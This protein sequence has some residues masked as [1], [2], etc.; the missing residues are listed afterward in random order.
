MMYALIIG[1]FCVTSI[2][3]WFVQILVRQGFA[4]YHQA[5]T[6]Q[7]RNDLGEMFLFLDPRQVWSASLVLCAACAVVTYLIA[8]NVLIV[9]MVSAVMLFA[10]PYV[11]SYAR[12]YRLERLERQLP[13][14]LLAL[15]GALRAGSGIQSALRQSVKHVP[16]PLSQELGLMLREQRM[17]VSFEQ[18]LSNLSHRVPT[19]SLSLIVSALNIA[20]QSGG[21]LAETLERIAVTLRTRLHLHGRVRALTS[22][23]RM[24][25]WVMAALPPGL[26]VVL[27]GL[28]PDTMSALW[29]TP[30]GW[31]VLLLIVVLETTG[32]FL[33]RRIVR[34]DV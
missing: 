2:A 25:A 3:L 17:G 12:Q 10:P 11:L 6:T 22:Q 18:A 31:M 27:H 28:D 33:I 34:I 21:S 14:L 13:D 7:T 5:F 29:T 16:A 24:Q 26:A 23:G 32:I 20:A 9:T 8:A 15:A 1:V 4:R 19:E 30:A